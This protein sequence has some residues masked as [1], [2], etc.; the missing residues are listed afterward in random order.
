[1]LWT[2]LSSP[3]AVWS[4][5]LRRMRSEAALSDLKTAG[6]L[7]AFTEKRGT[8][9][10]REHGKDLDKDYRCYSGFTAMQNKKTQ[11]D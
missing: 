9:T 6:L 4:L 1:M 8:A 5:R 11:E 3:G 7:R 10:Q 2:Q